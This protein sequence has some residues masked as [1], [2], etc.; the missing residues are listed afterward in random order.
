MARRPFLPG[1]ARGDSLRTQLNPLQGS[2]T[3]AEILT[4]ALVEVGGLVGPARGEGGPQRQQ[5]EGCLHH[6]RHAASVTSTHSCISISI[7]LSLYSSINFIYG[8]VSSLIIHIRVCRRHE[9]ISGG[10]PIHLASW[11][12]GKTGRRPQQDPAAGR[13]SWLLQGE[14]R[15]RRGRVG[16]P[17]RPR[18]HLAAAGPMM[19]PAAGTRTVTEGGAAPRDPGCATSRNALS[20][21]TPAHKHHAPPMPHQHAPRSTSQGKHISAVTTAHQQI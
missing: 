11:S 6:M 2:R 14:P 15:G 13:D 19:P 5:E 21:T 10:R 4:L 9:A 1:A 12:V 16:G 20:H 17:G 18:T 3:A 7:Y 8:T